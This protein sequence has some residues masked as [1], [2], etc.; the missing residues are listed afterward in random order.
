[1]QFLLNT[2]NGQTKKNVEVMVQLN[3]E[4]PAL[5]NDMCGEESDYLA[6][7]TNNCLDIYSHK[8]VYFSD[9][10]LK[11]NYEDV[12]SF[13]WLAI[14][15]QA[16][17]ERS[18]LLDTKVIEEIKTSVNSIFILQQEPDDWLL[19]FHKRVDLYLMAN[20]QAVEFLPPNI[21][22]FD[23]IL[24]VVLAEKAYGIPEIIKPKYYS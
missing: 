23:E 15:H 14:A 6:Y 10:C 16:Y 19:A 5:L 2:F 18:I 3:I 13:F 21:R 24:K 4:I 17:V 1:M 20:T 8:K 11:G 12:N 7:F 9:N 22:P